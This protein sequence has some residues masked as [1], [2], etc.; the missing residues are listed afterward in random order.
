L[1][2]KAKEN[3]KNSKEKNYTISGIK[4]GNFN[5]LLNK[6]IFIINKKKLGQLGLGNDKKL[7][8]PQEVKGI[9]GII[10]D[11]GAGSAHSIVVTS[12]GV[13]SFGLNYEV[14]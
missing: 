9:D 14:K 13:Y 11:V 1:G 4:K 6:R 2:V 10:R 7:S 5:F 8:F 3:I 12:K